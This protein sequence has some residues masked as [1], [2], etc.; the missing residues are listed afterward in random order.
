MSYREASGCK[1]R[2]AVKRFSVTEA[3]FD[4]CDGPSPGPASEV[5][6]TGG[7]GDWTW[8]RLEVGRLE[9]G[10]VLCLNYELSLAHNSFQRLYERFG[11]VDLAMS[12]AINVL[13]P[14]SNL[15]ITHTQSSILIHPLLAYLH[16][17][18]QLTGTFRV[19][20][21]RASTK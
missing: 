2:L 18:S 10:F 16:K 5:G 7:G 15:T 17:V 20:S 12:R 9:V 4:D 3:E 19:E 6:E 21:A 8:G 13:N 14:L 1:G 11:T